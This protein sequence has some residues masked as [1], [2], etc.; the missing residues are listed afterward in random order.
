ML[1]GHLWSVSDVSLPGH[2]KTVFQTLC[3]NNDA[4]ITSSLNDQEQWL[5]RDIE[6][7][8]LFKVFQILS[9]VH[10]WDCSQGTDSRV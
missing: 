8:Y 10:H 6:I 4:L 9:N 5:A 2:S 7:S 3:S 1:P